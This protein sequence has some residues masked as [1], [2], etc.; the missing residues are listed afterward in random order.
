MVVHGLCD[1]VTIATEQSC[2]SSALHFHYRGVR[3]IRYT[4]QD[5]RDTTEN[6][7]LI[8]SRSVCK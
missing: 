1:P 4:F 8:Q 7:V 3:C 6:H 5:F 2:I